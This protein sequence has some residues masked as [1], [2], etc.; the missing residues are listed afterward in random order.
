MIE[1]RY[2]F[3][4]FINEQFVVHCDTEEKA[5][6]L[7]KRCIENKISWGKEMIDVNDNRFKYYG[8]ETCYGMINGSLCFGSLKGFTGYCKIIEFDE[9]I[10]GEEEFSSAMQQVK[11]AVE[12]FDY[13]KLFYLSE[14]LKEYGIKIVD[15]QE[16][17]VFNNLIGF[18]CECGL[19]FLVDKNTC[20]S[21]IH[22][23]QIYYNFKCPN[24]SSVLEVIE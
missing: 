7:L 4:A 17:K 1:T 19:C 8:T 11:K 9:L 13:S 15:K 3:S 22:C 16:L 2:N 6:I 10:S 18:E 12:N 20:D 24:C 21:S 14:C 5:R 23:N